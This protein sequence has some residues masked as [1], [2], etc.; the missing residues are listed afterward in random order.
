M[1]I[2]RTT[3]VK[4]IW[5]SYEFLAFWILLGRRL[6]GKGAW[7]S[8]CA[9]WTWCGCYQCLLLRPQDYKLALLQAWEP[10]TSG[11]Q[12]IEKKPKTWFS[13]HGPEW[14]AVW[15]LWR[16]PGLLHA[17]WKQEKMKKQDCMVFYEIPL[18]NFKQNWHNSQPAA[19]PADP[20]TPKN[21]SHYY[22]M[23]VC[24]KVTE[25][26]KWHIRPERASA[27]SLLHLA[28]RNPWAYSWILT[29]C[30]TGQN[31]APFSLSWLSS[32]LRSAYFFEHFAN[33]ILLLKPAI[34]FMLGIG[35]RTNLV[36]LSCDFAH[37]AAATYRTSCYL[38]RSTVQPATY[39]SFH[40]LLSSPQTYTEAVRCNRSLSFHISSVNTER[41]SISTSI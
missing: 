40:G 27:T 19:T 14:D 36:N 38:A 10:R 28:V 20:K 31:C 16:R 8:G 12:D 24:L 7:S 32:S 29:R 4:T 17:P 11:H 25:S 23:R 30:K 18:R 15:T 6:R 21:T 34:C 26:N 2:L 39:D 9:C 41:V 37:F 1:E 13:F 3:S 22:S 33:Q 5:Q 35:S